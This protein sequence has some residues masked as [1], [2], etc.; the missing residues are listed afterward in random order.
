MSEVA[1]H[2]ARHAVCAALFDFTMLEIRADM[3]ND[4]CYVHV[5]FDHSGEKWDRLHLAE[6][7][8]V[9]LVGGLG[10]KNWPPPWPPRHDGPEADEQNLAAI[11]RQLGLTEKQWDGLI[12]V[13]T[14]IATNKSIRAAEGH[15]HAPQ[16]WP[17]PQTADRPK[18]YWTA[19]RETTPRRPNARPTPLRWRDTAN[20]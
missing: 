14:M 20:G 18:T 6:F 3:P 4:K 8:V 19:S 2:E 13:A 12:R 9:H 16:L 5:T 7:M 17:Q 11:V 10:D 15:L 1:G